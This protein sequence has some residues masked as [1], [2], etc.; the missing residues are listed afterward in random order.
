LGWGALGLAGAVPF[1]GQAGRGLVR[2]A[3]AVGDVARG[4]GAAA[5]VGRVV[6]EGR[7]TQYPTAELV[8]SRWLEQFAEFERTGERVENLIPSVR[9]RGFDDPLIL[10]VGLNGKATLIEGNHRLAAARQLG[11]E[12]VPVR[13]ITARNVRPTQSG[14]GAV[15]VNLR[16]GIG[17]GWD[18]KPSEIIADIPLR[19]AAGAAADV[20]RA[21]D[22]TPRPI[23]FADSIADD[24]LSEISGP[25][26]F[27]FKKPNIQNVPLERRTVAELAYRQGF[28]APPKVVDSQ[29]FDSIAPL[30]AAVQRERL[31]LQHQSAPDEN[32]LYRGFQTEADI[33]DQFGRFKTSEYYASELI[34]GDYYVGHGLRGHG[35][36][37][38]ANPVESLQYTGISRARYFPSRSDPQAILGSVVRARVA[39]EARLLDGFSELTMS[40]FR[41][42]R[43]G[44]I[45]E[46]AAANGY[47]GIRYTFYGADKA[48]EH[49][50]MLNRSALT[51]DSRMAKIDT[52]TAIELS[53]DSLLTEKFADTMF[54]DLPFVIERAD[55]PTYDLPGGTGL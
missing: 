37:F 13:V 3:G 43:F 7:W 48:P 44:D 19:Q 26:L 10:E 24:Y 40:E 16:E 5:D 50:V 28:E 33:N 1:F 36:Y 9:E 15:D 11:L 18:A 6:P 45:S 31:P 55:I 51:F 21:A 23:V 32:V 52:R 2:G 34:N 20:G 25:E 29:V 39:P 54:S 8:P 49:I 53:N 17:D 12:N 4:A 38:T 46:F 42:S 41:K 30:K 35:T 14:R 22:V 27:S 47:D